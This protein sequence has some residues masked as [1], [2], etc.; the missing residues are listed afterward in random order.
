M[1]NIQMINDVNTLSDKDFFDKYNELKT[2]F[3]ARLGEE[4]EDKKEG[5]KGD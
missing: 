5:N 3:I 2:D 1:S 4:F